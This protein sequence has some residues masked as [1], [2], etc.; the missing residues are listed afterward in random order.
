VAS[1]IVVVA[2][3]LSGC[4]YNKIQELDEQAK[5][6]W[7][8]VLNQYKRRADLIPNLVNVVKGYA[9]H[10]EKVLTDV[11]EARARAGAINVTPEM[12]ADEQAVAKFQQI[13]GEMTSALSRLIAIA[14]NYPNLKADAQFQGLQAQLEG[15]ENRIAVARGNYVKAIQEYNTLIRRFPTL[16]TAKVFGY[17]QKPQLLLEEAQSLQTAPKVEF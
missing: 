2:V 12:L 16:V 6:S 13:Q 10:E 15:T 5:S 17:Q 1:I 14:E 11:T 3:M 7:S 4:G 8:E 9:A